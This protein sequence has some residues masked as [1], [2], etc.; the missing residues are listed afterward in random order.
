MKCT[1]HRRRNSVAAVDS[2]EA[3]ASDEAALVETAD[4]E[5]A[6]TGHNGGKCEILEVDRAPIEAGFVADFVEGFV[7]AFEGGGRDFKIKHQKNLLSMTNIFYGQD[8]IFSLVRSSS[9]F[10][11]LN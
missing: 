10:T 8:D 4:F 6:S 7:E 11:S 5:A 1:E 3:V 9:A 2:D